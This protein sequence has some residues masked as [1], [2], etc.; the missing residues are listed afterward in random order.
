MNVRPKIV[1]RRIGMDINFGIYLLIVFI[2]LLGS[3]AILDGTRN[4]NEEQ[5]HGIVVKNKFWRVVCFLHKPYEK[6]LSYVSIVFLVLGYVY[7]LAVLSLFVIYFCYPSIVTDGV[8]FTSVAVM[9]AINIVERL[10]MPEHGS[11]GNH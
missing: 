4:I 5:D 3:W 9:L 11:M 6:H 8:V 1:Q 10:F 2:N 7:F